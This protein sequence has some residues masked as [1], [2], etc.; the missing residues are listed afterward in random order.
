MAKKTSKSSKFKPGKL[1]E[2]SS[3]ASAVMITLDPGV[4][5]ELL[6]KEAGS[7][8]EAFGRDPSEVTAR[9]VARMY[10]KFALQIQTASNA[11]KIKA[12]KKKLKL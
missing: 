11:A 10:E 7:W 8:W 3:D 9:E 12:S 4:A 2:V 1:M 6:R 5:C